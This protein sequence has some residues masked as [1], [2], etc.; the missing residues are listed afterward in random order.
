VDDDPDQ[1]A[2]LVA[3]LAD[4]LGVGGR[5]AAEVREALDRAVLTGTSMSGSWSSSYEIDIEI[6]DD[7]PTAESTRPVADRYEDL[8]AIGAGGMGEV[9][10]VRDRVLGRTVAMK[11][12]HANLLQRPVSAAR[13]AAE[14][15]VAAQLQHPGIP[16][17]HDAGQAPDGRLWFTMKEVRGRTLQDVIRE[18]HAASREGAWAPGPSGWTFH[19][20]VDAFAKVCEAMGYAHSRGVL[21]RDLKPDNVMLGAHGEV[22]VLD[23]GIAKVLGRPDQAVEEDVVSG[24]T[25]DETLA[26]RVGSVTGTAAYMAPEQ[27]TGEV[28]RLSPAS[29][30]YALGVCLYELLSGRLPYAA[31][32]VMALLT[33]KLAHEPMPLEHAVQVGRPN[34]PPL[35]DELVELCQRAMAK[36]PDARPRDAA[37]LAEGVRAWLE[38][39]RRRERADEVV[40][41]AEALAPKARSLR[42]EAVALRAEAERRLARVP[43]WAS[44]ADKAPGW[45]LIDDAVRKEREAGLLTLRAERLL[46]AALTH[47]PDLPDAH[48]ALARGYREEHTLAEAARDAERATR[49]EVRLR[50]HLDALPSVHLERARGLAYLEG[51][52]ALTLLTDPPGAEVWLR[53]WELRNRRLVA[54]AARRLGVTPLVEEPLP[55][56]SWLCEITAEGRATVRYPV[57]IGRGEHWDGIP[58]GEREPARIHLP[59]AHQ[60]GRG[61]VVVPA[62]WFRSGGDPGATGSLPA[63]RL[64]CDGFVMRRLP[65]SHRAWLTFLDALSASGRED[66]IRRCIPSERGSDLEPGAPLYQRGPDG[67]FVLPEGWS[68]GEPAIMVDWRA[69]RGFASWV[70]EH[71]GLPWRLPAE[72]EWE[73]AGRGVD[74]RVFPWGDLFDPSWCNVGD[75]HAEP[76]RTPVDSFPVDESPYGVRG[77]AGN[78]RDWCADA[79]LPDG[80]PCV[81]DRVGQAVPG[82]DDA[83]R[84]RRGGSWGDVA[85]RAR[86]ADRDWY[87]P[88]YRFD[89]LGV[90]LVRSCQPS[91]EPPRTNS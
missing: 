86:L 50:D 11:L 18:V 3:E 9:R 66:E 65:S 67:R 29:D 10:R 44:E 58:P 4:R 37:E 15:Q 61:D 60:I 16:P 38:G 53:P 74:G 20:L 75:S 17:V 59:F 40:A 22:L 6:D 55:M 39:A 42:K 81:G 8:G 77:L 1:L 21:H 83:W 34:A 51:T 70:A 73:K 47:A 31:P 89:Y 79:W 63:R 52:G 41:E 2:T 72:L 36:D 48:A 7:E 78:V 24:R 87:H 5:P 28:D 30:V 27:A 76:R 85:G 80:P 56:G 14:A 71:S 23:W 12:L 32:T 84:V 19:R 25:E 45:S 62:G 68:A 91:A 82:P 26:T 90:R 88:G 69:A 49:A 13:F 54:G 33:R 64:W 46:G 43:S 57:A 35:P